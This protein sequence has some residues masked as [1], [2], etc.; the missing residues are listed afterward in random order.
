M[1]DTQ[2]TPD[3]PRGPQ[4]QP[5]AQSGQPYAQP[6]QP[7]GASGLP[8]APTPQTSA[9]TGNPVGRVAFLVT[10]LSVGVGLI[11]QLVLQLL[12]ASIGFG[13]LGG[14]S[15]ILNFLV[16]VGAAAGLVL[17]IAALRRPAPHLLAAVA[18][19]VAANTVAGTLVSFV[20][21]LFYSIGF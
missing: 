16:F 19:G 6:G 17:G 4:E 9:S 20:S 1:S 10:V 5:Y 3:Q 18:V 15:S 8:A 13:L 14:V 11:G 2:P 12:S 7:Y 21:S